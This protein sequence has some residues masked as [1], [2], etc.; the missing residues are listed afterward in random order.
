MAVGKMRLL[1]ILLKNGGN[2]NSILEKI[3][4]SV[5]DETHDGILSLSV[6]RK[7]NMQLTEEVYKV[8]DS[9]ID[10]GVLKER[11]CESFAIERV[12]N[13]RSCYG[14]Q[15]FFNMYIHLTREQLTEEISKQN[16]VHGLVIVI[17]DDIGSCIH[18]KNVSSKDEGIQYFNKMYDSEYSYEFIIT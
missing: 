16:N 17:M 9:L 5:L 18:S 15:K 1:G 7:N 4:L 10:K 2:M 6:F 13:T 12:G 3:L 8:I 14:E 11:D